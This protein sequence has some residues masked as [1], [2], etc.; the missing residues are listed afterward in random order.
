MGVIDLSR[1]PARP[2]PILLLRSSHQIHMQLK[3]ERL[4]F[5]RADLE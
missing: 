2:H 1:A 3:I 4:N 5:G